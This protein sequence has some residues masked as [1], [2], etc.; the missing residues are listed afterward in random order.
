VG[1]EG[2]DPH[3]V[4][5]DHLPHLHPRLGGADHADLLFCLHHVVVVVAVVV[6]LVVIHLLL[7]QSQPPRA[8]VKF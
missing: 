8:V 7:V 1:V 3:D 4:P 6:V 2:V 5:G